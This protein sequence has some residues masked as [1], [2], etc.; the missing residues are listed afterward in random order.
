[1]RQAALLQ[2][3][4]SEAVSTA[5]PATLLMMLY[6]RLILDLDRAEGAIEAGQVP[7]TYLTNA[8]DIVHELRSSLDLNLWP[9]GQG[10]MALYD[11]VYTALVRAN[12]RADAAI[13]RECRDLLTPV[14]DAWR[15]AAGQVGQ[16]AGAPA[17]PAGAAAP[18][19]T[20]AAGA[21]AAG[22]LGVG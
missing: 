21:G 19:T 5:T 6:D 13:V 7:G 9:G 8:Q 1:M 10:L 16:G 3:F 14:R 2:K 4:R 22:H 15:E 17:E 12:I 11:Y 20:A 18:T